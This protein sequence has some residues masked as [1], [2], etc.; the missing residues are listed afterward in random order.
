M[1]VLTSVLGSS[2]TEPELW[3]Q[4][5]ENLATPVDD[6]TLYSEMKESLVP[7]RMLINLSSSAEKPLSLVDTQQ[8]ESMCKN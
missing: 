5:F 8:T 6:Q 7:R 1:S 4:Y 3:A 2:T